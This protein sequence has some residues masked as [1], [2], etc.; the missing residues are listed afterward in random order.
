LILAKEALQG[1]EK[2]AKG[3]LTHINMDGSRNILLAATDRLTRI[4]QTPAPATTLL[5]RKRAVDAF[6]NLLEEVEPDSDARNEL[7]KAVL[8][9]CQ[10][11]MVI[12]DD[13]LALHARP[14][15]ILVMGEEPAADYLA[16]LIVDERE[17]R[18]NALVEWRNKTD[19]SGVR[20]QDLKRLIR[21]RAALALAA[22]PQNAKAHNKLVDAL[23]SRTVAAGYAQAALTAMGGERA[24]QAMVQYSLQQQ[25]AE[26]YFRPMEEAREEGWKLLTDLKSKTNKSFDFSLGIAWFTVVVGVILFGI[27]VWL[28]VRNGNTANPFAAGTAIMGLIGVAAGIA[29]TYFWKPA[30]GL[31]KVTSE[32]AQLIMSFENYLG[33]MRLIGLG[34]AH[35]YTEQNWGQFQFLDQV[36]DITGDSL[37]ESTV[38]LPGIGQW[39]EMEA[40]TLVTVPNFTGQPADQAKRIA[41]VAGLY[42]A[43]SKTEYD[44]DRPD[45]TVKSQDLAAGIRVGRGTAVNLVATTVQKPIVAMPDLKNKTI[46]EALSAVK[47]SGLL[48][49]KVNLV[50]GNQDAEAVVAGQNLPAGL[51]VGYGAKVQLTLKNGTAPP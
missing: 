31:L 43:S 15:L 51:E 7:T 1:L 4:A 24:I 50:S 29:G 3:A 33:R 26:R 37:R 35:A 18:L 12:A 16:E 13:H 23:R 30:R 39:P 10:H 34:F 27:S 32:I 44:P 22:I 42:V 14:T 48:V 5:I 19:G 21:E 6:D 25:V 40:A 8:L 20:E 49:E 36:T 41:D 2:I 11:L 28:T 45:Q 47:E 38:A 46:V 9:P 17:E